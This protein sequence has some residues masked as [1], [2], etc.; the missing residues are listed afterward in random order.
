MQDGL[1]TQIEMQYTQRR[2]GHAQRM[3]Q[4]KLEVAA[5]PGFQQ[6]EQ[7]RIAA[8]QAAAKAALQDGQHTQVLDYQLTQIDARQR[9]LLEQ[10]GLAPDY[11]D[12]AS[13]CQCTQCMDAGYITHPNGLRTRCKC[14][15]HALTD[16]R[17][18]QN[19]LHAALDQHFG[20]YDLSIFPDEGPP[21][22]Q[23]VLMQ[24]LYDYAW[25]FAQQFPY[26]RKKVV[27]F[28]GSAG[29]GKTFLMNCIARRVTERGFTAARVP[30]YRLVQDALKDRSI[31]TLSI[32]ADLLALD[33]LGTEPLYN[34][35]TVETL[36]TIL[37][38]RLTAGKHTLISTNLSLKQLSDRYTER[39]ASRLFSA[40][41]AHIIR[42]SGQ[43]VRRK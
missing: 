22:T 42:L 35:I 26:T 4:R 12:E 25:E 36:Y 3:A 38:E 13:L 1:Y 20:T 21:P 37:N 6:L 16:A 11:L 40:Q 8:L 30:S 19:G 10:H 28:S 31:S 39:I 27:L 9:K 29:L 5:L 43:D 24:R 34:N 32:Q 17:L 14:L 15:T 33:D 2:L 7:D 18:A 41:D 23:R